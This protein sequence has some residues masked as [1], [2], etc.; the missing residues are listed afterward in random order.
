MFKKKKVFV[1]N[2]M[3]VLLLLPKQNSKTAIYIPFTCYLDVRS[4][5]EM[6]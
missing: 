5:Q 2:Q 6:I 1:L 3:Y 4:K